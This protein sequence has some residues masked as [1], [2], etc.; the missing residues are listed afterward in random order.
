M[1]TSSVMTKT[2]RIATWNVNSLKARR[3]HVLTYLS[4]GKADILLLQELKLQDADFPHDA[5]KEIGFSSVCHGQKTYNGVAIISRFDIEN[6]VR[7][8]PN[9]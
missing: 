1:M 6:I 8:L 7:G 9:G 3:E 2:A 4:E 5:F